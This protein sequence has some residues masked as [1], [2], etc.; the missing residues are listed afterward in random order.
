MV[1][2]PHSSRD[3]HSTIYVGIEMR[4]RQLT[5]NVHYLCSKITSTVKKFDADTN[6]TPSNLY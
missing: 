1:N 4:Y 5:V 6:G 2:E 3:I